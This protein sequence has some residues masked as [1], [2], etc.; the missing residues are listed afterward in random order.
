MY[1]KPYSTYLRG[2]I[3]TCEVGDLGGG[4][5]NLRF[6][7]SGCG[8]EKALRAIGLYQGQFSS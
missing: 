8:S 5:S 7:C 4:L 2:T 3:G 1:P 6:L